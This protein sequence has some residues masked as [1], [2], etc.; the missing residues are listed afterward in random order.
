[1]WSGT[2]A[3]DNALVLAFRRHHR[4]SR[5]A[6]PRLATC[7]LLVLAVLSPLAAADG[8][9]IRG[10]V[11]NGPWIPALDGPTQADRPRVRF[12]HRCYD[13]FGGDN[14]P[15]EMTFEFR[16]MRT[17]LDSS[18]D[19]SDA[20]HN[21]GGHQ[22]DFDTH[23]M[24]FIVEDAEV[25]RLDDMEVNNISR[26]GEPVTV[27]TGT[28]PLTV[29]GEDR[30]ATVSLPMAEAAGR[31]EVDVELRTPFIFNGTSWFCASRCF[32]E[33]THKY[34]Y[35]AQSAVRGLVE[36]P[37]SDLYDKVRSPEPEHP[38]GFYVQP[39]IPGSLVL[40]AREFKKGHD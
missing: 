15:C 32:D 11:S 39:S 13:R 17:P 4:Q 37:D 38:E 20:A 19:G 1:M 6:G 8:V 12:E 18:T 25:A 34:N 29:D 2:S 10:T 24:R 27:I 7:A 16:G 14:I 22:H 9:I 35:N 40:I 36:I 31:V 33:R 3:F 28:T 26:D 30:Y 21:S 23:P 5:T